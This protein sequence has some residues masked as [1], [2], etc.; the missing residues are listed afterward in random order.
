MGGSRSHWDN[1][2]VTKAET[3]VS[4]FQP[5]SIRSLELIDSASPDREASVIDVGG[6]AATLV[7][8]L[9]ARGFGDVTVLDIAEPA[10]DRSKVRLGSAGD[11]VGWI[12][13]DITQ[14][15][16]ARTWDIWHDRAVFHFLTERAQ[17][18]AYI[19]ALTAGTAPGATVVMATFA[20]DG[21]D[22]CSGLPVQRYSPETL[23]S[24]LGLAFA[25][26]AHANE[27][28]K[29]PWGSEQRFSYTVLKRQ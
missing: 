11:R 24:R 2:Y 4:W 3:A 16:P 26:T 18:D 8:D 17:Q 7:D 25:L 19:A 27:T 29:T 14:W 13:A 20:L 15:K 23:A 1:V 9:L 5:H 12:V 21:P 22:K 6:G 10:L 28:H